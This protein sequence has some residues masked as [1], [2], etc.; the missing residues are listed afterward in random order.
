VLDLDVLAG[1][2]SEE[3]R[4]AFLGQNARDLFRISV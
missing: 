4:A 2:F 1:S 3:G